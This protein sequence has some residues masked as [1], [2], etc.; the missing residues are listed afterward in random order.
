MQAILG[1]GKYL[2]AIPFLIFGIF[3]LMGAEAMAPMAFGSTLLVYLTGIALILATVS[4]FM[5]KYD[6]LATVLLG[7]FLLLTVALVH[8]SGAIDGD[9]AATGNVLKD[10]SLAGA[11]W[12]Y[13]GQ[14]ARDKSV[15]G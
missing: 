9:Q 8:L 14:I 1:L 6:K 3:H 10:L 4:I 13:A 12:L 7:V 15:I 5:G 2:F 11:S